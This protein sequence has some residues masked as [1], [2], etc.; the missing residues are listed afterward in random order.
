MSLSD[1]IYDQVRKLE[2]ENAW[3]KETH[4]TNVYLRQ[5]LIS[6]REKRRA[7]Y[8][9]FKRVEESL[10]REVREYQTRVEAADQAGDHAAMRVAEAGRVAYKNALEQVTNTFSDLK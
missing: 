6:S 8:E 5:Q 3:T 4:D 9:A 2:E 7:W 10:A 1:Q